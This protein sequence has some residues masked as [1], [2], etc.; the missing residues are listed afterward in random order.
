VLAGREC[1]DAYLV[2]VVDVEQARDDR[3][4]C[5]R[6]RRSSLHTAPSV[7]APREGQVREC[8]H[9]Q[10]APLGTVLEGPETPILAKI[11]L[12]VLRVVLGPETLLHRGRRRA[13]RNDIL[14]RSRQ[15]ARCY[16][17]SETGRTSRMYLA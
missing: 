2:L 14:E 4:V 12:L 10:V 16:T 11:C 3:R 1:L 8:A 5:F 6:I 13:M 17:I 15:H 7:P 9:G